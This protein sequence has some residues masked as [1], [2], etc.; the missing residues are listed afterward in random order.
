MRKNAFSGKMIKNI[1]NRFKKEFMKNCQKDKI[2]EQL[3][4]L[5]VNGIH[6]SNTYSK[7]YTLKQNEVL[8]DKTIYV[9]FAILELSK[10]HM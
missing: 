9:G 3:S 1:R 5:T 8:S 6:K 7:R 4:K 2:T 10:L